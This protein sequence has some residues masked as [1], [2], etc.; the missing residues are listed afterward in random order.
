MPPADNADTAV[1]Q[2][3]P[4]AETTRPR[5][6]R[7]RLRYWMALLLVVVSV[8]AIVVST[9][10]IWAHESVFDTDKYVATVA[11]LIRDPEVQESIAVNVTDQAITASDLQT[12][13]ADVL[14]DRAAFLA[15]PITEQIR[16]YVEN[17][18]QRFLATPQAEELWIRINEVG[19]E[20]IVA[21]LRGESDVVLIGEDDVVLN[22]FP[23]ISQALERVQARL[24]ELLGSRVTL[25]QID[26]EATPEEA[27]AQL[28]AAL[29]RPLPA[30]FGTVTLLKGDQGYQAQRAVEIFDRLVV[31][32]VIV[33]IALVVAAILVSPRRWLT[34]LELSLG[35]LLAIVIARVAVAELQQALLDGIKQEGIVPVV[36][37]IV[38]S[39]IAGLR[40]FF[41]WLIV[42]AALVAVVAY[43]GSRPGWM[44]ALGRW[45]AELF[46]V[47]SD[48]ATPQSR[49]S[50]WLSS[51]LDA[52][53]AGGVGVAVVAMLIAP[54]TF[55]WMLLVVLVLV[56]YELLLTVW[57]VSARVDEKQPE[58]PGG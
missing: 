2:A 22:L 7:Y 40:D 11:P 15:G 47:A 36:S 55:S 58:T 24:P 13:I 49:A 28:S 44:E 6:A 26:P 30:D 9:I 14:P 34:V 8:L 51:H 31:L 42:G 43:V 18:V 4:T 54:K 1:T 37:S 52:L 57:A 3:L 41:V 17:G 53:R 12:R 50:R 33:T 48:L 23:L 20:R 21:V 56:A 38:D 29:G 45:V 39:A 16:G 25:P 19:H 35:L 27:R 10:A 32:I 46:G 5:G